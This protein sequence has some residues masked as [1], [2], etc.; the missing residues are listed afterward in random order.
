MNQHTKLDILSIISNLLF[1][2]LGYGSINIYCL[3]IANNKNCGIYLNYCD[4]N[5][6]YIKQIYKGIFDDKQHS[7]CDSFHNI[8][9]IKLLY[10]LS[11][12]RVSTMV[13]NCKRLKSINL[14]GCIHIL[15]TNCIR[16][17]TVK[18]INLSLCDL[19]DIDTKNILKK[20]PLLS[21]LNISWNRRL[22]H[23]T[24]K[25]ISLYGLHLTELNISYSCIMTNKLL[26]ILLDKCTN[27]TTIICYG[28]SNL[29]IPRGR[30]ARN[31]L[32]IIDHNV[33]SYYKRKK[34]GRIA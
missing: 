29:S 19:V 2:F 16:S 12:L 26:D 5:D 23:E 34:R 24:I 10:S 3:L 11:E 17:N 13:N 4:L 28:Y 1:S 18:E 33:K 25:S 14:S 20:C 27:L 32:V 22:S 31:K 21:V 30:V 15:D 9:H 7:S 8:E 6:K